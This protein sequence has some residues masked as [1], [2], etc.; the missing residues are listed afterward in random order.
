MRVGV[1]GVGCGQQKRHRQKD[2]A[3]FIARRYEYAAQT[4]VPYV[5]EGARVRG[6]DGPLS[7]HRLS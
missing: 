3:L 4:A 2:D 5:K 6:L 7:Q 1:H